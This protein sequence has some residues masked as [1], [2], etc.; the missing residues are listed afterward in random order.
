MKTRST[1]VSATVE[2]IPVARRSRNSGGAGRPGS[3]QWK[4]ILE[5]RWQRKI[6]EVVI[7]SQARSGLTSEPDETATVP[8]IGQSRRLGARLDAALGEVAA[9]EEA[10]ARMDDGSYGICAGCDRSMAA[11]WLADAPETRYCPDCS[12]RLVSWQPPSHRKVAGMRR[13]HAP[14]APAEAQ[15]AAPKGADR[16]R[17]HARRA[18]STV[19]AL[20]AVARHAA[21]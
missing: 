10:L 5:S 17:R 15:Q 20:S 21:R 14:T 9:L 2:S 12:L 16:K 1:S 13:A 8:G 11:E 19:P 4:L 18:D 3:R 7:L 6:D